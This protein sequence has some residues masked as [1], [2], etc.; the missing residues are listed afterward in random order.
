MKRY[1]IGENRAKPRFWIEGSVLAAAGFAR[2]DKFTATLAPGHITLQRDTDG[3]RTV[4]G[5]RD[6]LVVDLAGRE[7]GIVGP[8]GTVLAVTSIKAGRITFKVE[9]TI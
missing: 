4:S 7:V 1:R 5:H 8:V 3:K 2:G 9:A 6:K